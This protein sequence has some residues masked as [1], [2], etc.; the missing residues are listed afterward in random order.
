MKTNAIIENILERRSIRAFEESPIPHEDRDAYLASKSTQ[1][2][3]RSSM[4]PSSSSSSSSDST[5]KPWS[6]TLNPLNMMPSLGQSQAPEQKTEQLARDYS[7]AAVKIL[8]SIAA[9]SQNSAAAR[10]SA[11]LGVLDRGLG[12]PRQDIEMNA[13][14]R[15]SLSEYTEDELLALLGRGDGEGGDPEEATVAH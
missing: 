8:I 1:T 13:N 6:A 2:P 9:N 7:E 5:S 14:V 11:A 15:R 12:K 3:S 10:V 4:A